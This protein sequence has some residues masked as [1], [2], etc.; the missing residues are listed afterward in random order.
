MNSLKWTHDI[1]EVGEHGLEAT[2]T[3]G[4]DQCAAVAAQLGLVSCD[5]LDVHYKIRPIAA[6]RL[7]LEATLDAIVVQECVVT[8][9]PVSS[10]LSEAFELELW[11][12]EKFPQTSEAT[13][14]PLGADEPERIENGVIDIGRIVCDHLAGLIDP[15]PRK[16]GVVFS[17]RDENDQP[18]AEKPFAKLENLL[19]RT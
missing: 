3:A 9:D 2:R 11:P 5:K 13:I 16:P 7:R 4:P 18:G 1:R 8:L 17:W 10:E 14:D 19:R 15:Y 6:G 12:A